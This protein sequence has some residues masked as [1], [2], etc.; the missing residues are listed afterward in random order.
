MSFE[1][2]SPVF[3]DMLLLTAVDQKRRVRRDKL[4]MPDEQD[5]R[6]LSPQEIVA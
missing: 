3:L 4:K 2:N 6:H 1:L 5:T